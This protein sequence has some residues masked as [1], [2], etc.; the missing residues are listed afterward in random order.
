M[1]GGEQAA[2]AEGVRLVGADGGDGARSTWAD[3]GA[4]PSAWQP[5]G[6]HQS[7]SPAWG[8][9]ATTKPDARRLNVRTNSFIGSGGARRAHHRFRPDATGKPLVARFLGDHR[10]FRNR[11]DKASV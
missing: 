3:G 11:Q 5:L 6:A 1:D 8:P 9:G 10:L 7:T 4:I 2:A